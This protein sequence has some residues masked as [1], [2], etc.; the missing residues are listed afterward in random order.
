MIKEIYQLDLN[1]KYLRSFKEVCQLEEKGLKYKEIWKV[2]NRNNKKYKGNIYIYKEDYKNYQRDDSMDIIRYSLIGEEEYIYTN[3]NDVVYDNF[4][5]AGVRLA[6]N[7]TKLYYKDC[8]WRYRHEGK[9]SEDEIDSI[10]NIYY[11]NQ[12]RKLE[13][14]KNRHKYGKILLI[15]KNGESELYNSIQDIVK[16]GFSRSFIYDSIKH[17]NTIYGEYKVKVIN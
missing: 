6:L 12:D 16:L 4:A 14:L 13:R 15:N 2:C 9:P 1:G 8:I 11:N 5:I 10:N 7:K 17:N 3:I